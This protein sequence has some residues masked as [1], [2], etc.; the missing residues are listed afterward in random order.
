MKLITEF[1]D[2]LLQ[3]LWIEAGFGQIAILALQCRR[4][5]WTRLRTASAF[6]I[7]LLILSRKTPMNRRKK[8]GGC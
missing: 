1:I 6:H 5:L 4:R 7:D 2:Q 8:V 3:R